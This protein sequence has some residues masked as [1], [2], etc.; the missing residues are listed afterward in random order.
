MTSGICEISGT[1]ESDDCPLDG[2]I[3]GGACVVTVVRICDEYPLGISSA[4][5]MTAWCGC[6]GVCTLWGTVS[7]TCDCEAA[8]GPLRGD[9]PLDGTRAENRTRFMA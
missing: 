6:F 8:W 2:T 5:D 7:F 9:C 3:A 4:V 1:N